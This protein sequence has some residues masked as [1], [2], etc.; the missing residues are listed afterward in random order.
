MHTYIHTVCIYVCLSMYICVH[1]YSIYVLNLKQWRDDAFKCQ[2]KFDVPNLI[3]KGHDSWQNQYHSRNSRFLYNT[4]TLSLS[5]FLP[6]PLS[7]S[8]S[9]SPTELR[10]LSNFSRKDQVLER[11]PFSE[12]HLT[13]FLYQLVSTINIFYSPQNVILEISSWHFH[14]LHNFIIA[15]HNLFD[16]WNVL[17]NYDVKPSNPSS[18]LLTESH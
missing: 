11:F 10:D 6:P 2:I 8:L 15:W 9:R 3:D 1:I 16:S 18:S 7:V 14:Q 17:L 5:F 13:L 4:H 12:W